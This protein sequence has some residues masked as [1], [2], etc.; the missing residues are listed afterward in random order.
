MIVFF[1]GLD[2]MRMLKCLTE[3]VLM[4]L[5]LDFFVGIPIVLL[6][7]YTTIS[8]RFLIGIQILLPIL[9]IV[10]IFRYTDF[11]LMNKE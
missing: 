1:K 4:W 10:W 2:Y 11:R 8:R 6:F 3:I 7:K 9:I 5:A